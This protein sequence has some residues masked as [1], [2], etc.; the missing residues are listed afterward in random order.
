M[1]ILIVVPG[2]LVEHVDEPVLRRAVRVDVEGGQSAR[3]GE[4]G[5]WARG[6][7]TF[8][9]TAIGIGRRDPDRHSH[10]DLGQLIADRR[11]DDDPDDV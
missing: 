6:P 7:N 4:V 11:I 9:R 10:E 3:L 8:R 1:G 2:D 5:A